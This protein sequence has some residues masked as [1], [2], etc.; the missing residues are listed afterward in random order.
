MSQV[1]RERHGGYRGLL[2]YQKARIVYQ[3]TLHFCESYFEPRDRTKEQMIQAARSCKQ[4]I[5]EGSMASRT[6]SRNELHLTSVARASLEELLEDYR[7]FL[8]KR[9]MEEWPADHPGR[10]RVREL[11]RTQGADYSTF[12]ALVEGPDV[13]VAANTIVGLIHITSYLLSRQLLSLEDRMRRP[14]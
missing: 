1:E 5:V 11:S 9:R 7:D 2:S 13:V 10:A 8:E 12:Q 3:A 14:R 6:S 4:N